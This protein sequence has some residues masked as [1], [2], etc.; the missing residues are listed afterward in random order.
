[1]Q[2]CAALGYS[3]SRRFIA[4]DQLDSLPASELTFALRIASLV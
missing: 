1:M 3:N 2:A 4:P